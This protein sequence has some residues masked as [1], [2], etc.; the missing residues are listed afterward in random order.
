M[1]EG[2]DVPSLDGVVFM[3][4][5]RSTVDVVQSVGR[6]MRKS[7]N[8]SYGYI[9][10]PVVVPGGDKAE[11]ILDNSRFKH[12]WDVMNALRSHDPRLIAEMSIAGL[13]KSGSRRLPPRVSV[14][15]LGI[16]PEKEQQLYGDLVALMTSRLVKKVGNVNYVQKYGTKMGA[17]AREAEAIVKEKYEKESHA[18]E[19]IDRFHN[20]MKK[21]ISDSISLSDTVGMI[22]DHV[23]LKVVFDR[24]FAAEF[25]SNNPVSKKLDSILKQLGLGHILAELGDFYEDVRRETDIINT[26]PDKNHRHE[27]RQ[28][29]LKEIYNNYMS[30]AHKDAIDKGIVY[31]PTELVDFI[32]NSTQDILKKNMH[33]TLG[34]ENVQILEPF[35]G[36]GTFLTRLI[37]SGMLDRSLQK[38][39]LDGMFAN[40]VKLLAYYIASVNIET[41]YK[42]R[43]NELGRDYTYVPFPNISY[44]DTFSQNPHEWDPNRMGLVRKEWGVDDEYIEALKGRISKQNRQ[45]I[46]VIMSNPPWGVAPKSTPKPKSGHNYK[47]VE[48]TEYEISERI[49]STYGTKTSVGKKKLHDWYV[50]ALRWTSDRIGRCGVVG[51]VI[52]GSILRSQSFAGVRA[53]LHDE[54][55]EIYCFDVRGDAIAGNDGRNV[56]EYSGKAAGGTKSSVAIMF[57]I[58]NP[59]QTATKKHKL[60]YVRLEDQ[61]RTGKQKRVRIKKLTSIFKIQNWETIRPDTDHN[62]LDHPNTSFQQH[63]PIESGKDN[64]GIFVHY[65]NGV[66]TARDDWAYNSSHSKLIE[67]MQTHIQYINQHIHDPNLKENHD[68]KKMKWDDD[69]IERIKKRG[70]QIFKTE[71][72]RN[73]LYRPFFTQHLYFDWV[74]NARWY[75]PELMPNGDSDNLIMLVSFKTNP[76]SVLMTNLTP[77]LHTIGSNKCFALY[78]YEINDMEQFR[79]SQHTKPEPSKIENISDQILEVYRQHYKNLNITKSDIFYYVYGMLHH[80]EYKKKYT[81]NLKVSLPKIP[82]A[83]QFASFVAIGKQL[84]DLHIHFDK[85]ELRGLKMT[86]IEDLKVKPTNMRFIQTH[87]GM[88]V[89]HPESVLEVNG[90]VLY[91]NLPQIRYTVNGRTP[92]GW[93]VERVKKHKKPHKISGISN[94][95]FHGID[96]IGELAI[97]IKKLLYVGVESDR[98]IDQLPKEFEHKTPPKYESLKFHNDE[99][100]IVDN[101][102]SK[103]RKKKRS[104]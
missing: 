44:T 73:S 23:I 68:P 38:K 5:K 47:K 96:S 37:D 24:L 6:V 54:F 32:I 64:C 84:A 57:L 51:F 49:E 2:V 102:G 59:P 1:S 14:D 4:P 48:H 26:I 87:N 72:I 12:V 36:T 52:N 30:A 8:K 77:D 92:L 25:A 53:F 55:D 15:F 40:E 45:C 31:T 33:K 90:A 81:N 21:L 95:V 78:R 100:Q 3:S 62:W 83:P 28:N 88:S 101:T 103:R 16:D 42:N 97:I 35:A 19:K 76:F 61:Y 22:A 11:E 70:S 20:S 82:L 46:E 71:K 58:K 63:I 50:R 10:L 74:F 98:L 43:M 89:I 91:D 75:V 39:Y 41:T 27:T 80:P 13:A 17:Y 67:N 85:K 34:D 99:F 65:C 9:I 86:H 93:F 69:G 66:V 29:F 18:K 104:S 56:F 94:N 79:S 7:K 60:Y